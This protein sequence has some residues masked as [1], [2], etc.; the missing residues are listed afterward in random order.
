MHV[1]PHLEFGDIIFHNCAEYLMD[2]IES[3]QYQAGLIAT[4][5]WQ[6]TSR[7]KLYEELGWESLSSR[8]SSRRLIAYHKIHSNNAPAYL[9]E[10]V[11][12]EPPPS[13][14]S[15][16]YKR[17]FFP[18][19]FSNWQTLDPDLKSLD[20]SKFKSSVIKSSR[21]S[22]KDCFNVSDRYGLKLLTCLRVEHS[23]LRAHRFS[24][25]FNCSDPMCACGIEDE[26]IDHYLL[27]C[28]LFAGPRALLLNKMNEIFQ[29]NVISEIDNICNVLLYGYPVFCESENKLILTNTIGFI[30][31]SK[32]FKTLEAFVAVNE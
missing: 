27:R 30:K 1:R 31:S 22:K 15:D 12:I 21:P 10:Y 13:N 6:K 24:K 19:C 8:R 9:S 26:T 11:L 16:R 5:C 29:T 32:R 7:V 4:G 25:N 3:I 20:P 17:T 2:M 28:P 18:D 23:D 14:C